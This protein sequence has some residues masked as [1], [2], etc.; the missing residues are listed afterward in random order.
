MLYVLGLV[1]ADTMAEWVPGRRL[2]EA[3]SN[4]IS[5]YAWQKFVF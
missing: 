5:L 2:E 1:K 4:G 3:N